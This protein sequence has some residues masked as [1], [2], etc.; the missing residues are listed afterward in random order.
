MNKHMRLLLL[1][2]T[3]SLGLTLG[4]SAEFNKINT[5]K[6]GTF[7]DV[8]DPAWY[9]ESV[10]NAYEFGIMQGDSASTFSPEGN[11][12]VAEGITIAARIH[13]TMN[14]TEIKEADGEWYKMY[15]DYA[16][17][18]EIM[19]EDTFSDYNVKIKRSE[20]ATLLANVCGELPTINDVE[21]IADINENAPYYNDVL[22]LYSAGILTGN[23][24]Y[25]NF[26]PGSNLTRAEIA[27]MAVR[28]ADKNL[29]VN[30]TFEELDVRTYSDGYFLIDNISGT[31][32][33]NNSIAN[34]WKY[35]NRFEFTNTSGWPKKYVSDVND[36]I[37]TALIREFDVQSDGVLT[38]EL[39]TEMFSKNSGLYVAFENDKEER[40]FGMTEK[41]GMWVIF[42]EE[43]L[44]TDIPC[45]ASLEI[46]SAEATIDFDNNT[47]RVYIN[48]KEAGTVK[49][50]ADAATGRL[51]LGTNEKGTGSV[52]ISHVK[53]IKNYAVFDRFPAIDSN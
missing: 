36:T 32:R 16:V 25:G 13:E 51:V 1:G 41:D 11:L 46:V 31:G 27:T 28:I 8:A 30:K 38:L 40:L 49:I 15:V 50:P 7:T 21:K 48:N 24:E 37:F 5:Y 9:S 47:M 14:G 29:R 10:K 52:N 45:P 26:A 34:G 53:L 35:D 17:E 3:A 2:I 43:E 4:A 42:G 20:M 12:T 22:S 33:T 44:V 18:N 6:N 23:D 19:E 39:I